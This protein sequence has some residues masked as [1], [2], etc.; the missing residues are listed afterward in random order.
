VEAESQAA[1]L[2]GITL[3]LLLLC[4]GYG[5]L[6]ATEKS[7]TFQHSPETVHITL[8]ASQSGDAD[9]P[10]YRNDI[11][12]E[13]NQPLNIQLAGD[14]KQLVSLLQQQGWQQAERLGWSNVLR[15]LS[16]TAKLETLPIP[17]QVHDARHEELIMVK[18]QPNQ[19]RL[20]LRLWSTRYRLDPG[21]ER[22]QI[23]NVT[24]QG[25]ESV[26]SMLTIPRTIHQFETPVEILLQDLRGV[27]NSAMIKSNSLIK[28]LF[29]H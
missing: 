24:L 17:P 6:H 29:S 26:I 10:Q 9:L 20:L 2:I 14:E 22:I 23:G 27:E 28:L 19:Q 8:Q 4:S 3:L 13:R 11:F 1:T 15:L 21:G 25:A 12:G 16:P 7:S 18:P 5:W